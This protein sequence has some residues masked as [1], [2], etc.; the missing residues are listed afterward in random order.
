MAGEWFSSWFDSPYYHVLYQSHDDREARHFIDNMLQPLTFAPGARLLDLACGKGRH[1]RYLAEKGFDVTGVDISP[2]SI[3]FARHVEHEHLAFYQHDMRLPFR[4]NY[5]DGILN[6]F[7]SFGYFDTDSDHVRTLTNVGKGLKPGGLFLLDFFNAN[8]VRQHLVPS[9]E[10]QLDGISFHL[11]KRIRKN[12]IY[13]KVEFE[14]GGRKFTFLERVRL[15]NL[16]DFQYMFKSAGLE[17]RQTFGDYEM[18][19]FYGDQSRRL[20]IV[21]QKPI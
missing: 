13:K 10:K 15:F 20:I 14:A 21:A 16:L 2:A 7:T 4:F 18:R 3:G 5:F 19:P 12:R 9:E 8:W 1:A 11:K 17:I 6:I